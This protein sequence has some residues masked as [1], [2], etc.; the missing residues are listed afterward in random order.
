MPSIQGFAMKDGK[1]TEE[2]LKKLQEA[3]SE[4][5]AKPVD[6]KSMF[7]EGYKAEELK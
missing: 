7:G 4:L 5:N 3:G 6:L 2:T 1:I